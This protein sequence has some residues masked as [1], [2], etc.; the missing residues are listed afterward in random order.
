MRRVA[1]NV[2]TWCSS[3]ARFSPVVTSRSS[4]RASRGWRGSGPDVSLEIVG[5]NR[6]TP[7]VDFEPLVGCQRRRPIAS[8]SA[9]TFPRRCCA[10]LYMR[11]ASLRLPLRI[12]RIRPHVR[13]RR[14]LPGIPIVVL[15]TPVAR[16][17]YGMRPSTCHDRIPRSFTALSSGRCLTT[18]NVRGSSSARRAA[19]AVFVARLRRAGAR[20]VARQLDAAESETCR[21][22][23][24]SSSPTTRRRTSTRASRR[25]LERSRPIDNETLVVDNASPDGTA[26]RGPATLAWRDA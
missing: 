9:P 10:T 20:R 23:R 1:G 26:A 7:R 16:E 18:R 19:A 5:D 11:R 17:V 3:S 24:S 15:D 2:T 4:S 12:R 22:S 8:R 14:S 6:T 13:S 21:D 25:S